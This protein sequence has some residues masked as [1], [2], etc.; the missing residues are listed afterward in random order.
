MDMENKKAMLHLN[1]VLVY[2]ILSSDEMIKASFT[3]PCVL[4]GRWIHDT[5]IHAANLKNRTNIR[6]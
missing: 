4:K 2:F 1:P 5:T 3:G 6:F